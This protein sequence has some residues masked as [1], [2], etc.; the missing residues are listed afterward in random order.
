MIPFVASVPSQID[1]SA[2]AIFG[3]PFPNLLLLS[4]TYYELYTA[5]VQSEA[6][7]GDDNKYVYIMKRL[8]VASGVCANGQEKYLMPTPGALLTKM[9][10]VMKL[11]DIEPVTGLSD[12]VW[13]GQGSA[14]RCFLVKSAAQLLF[15]IMLQHH[16]FKVFNITTYGDEP[17]PLK[18]IGDHAIFVGNRRCVSVNTDKLPSVVANC[19]Y[20]VKCTNSSMKIYKYDLEDEVEEMVSEAVDS[21]NPV[22]SSSANCPFTLDQ[23]LSSYTFNVRVSQLP[24]EEPQFPDWYYSISPEIV[25]ECVSNLDLNSLIDEISD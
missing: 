18:N 16:Q 9:S 19:I 5:A 6:F 13:L 17:E 2:A 14:N 20:Y 22:T 15:V 4:D 25:A 21:F 7:I 23:H 1:I 3:D 24:M 10:A 11:F 8:F 12:Y